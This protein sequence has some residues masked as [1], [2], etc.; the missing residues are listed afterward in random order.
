MTLDPAGLPA[1]LDLLESIEKATLRL[2]SGELRV[3]RNQDYKTG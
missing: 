1:D 2:V 3:Y